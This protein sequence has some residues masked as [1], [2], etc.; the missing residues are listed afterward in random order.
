VVLGAAAQVGLQAF[1]LRKSALRVSLNFRHPALK[2]ILRLYLP[3]LGGLSVMLVGVA[4]DRNLA[5][6]TG[7]QSLAWMQAATY[8]VQLPLGLVATA[9]SFAILPTL[10]RAGAGSDFRRTLVF[11]LKVVLF[12]MLPCVVGLMILAQP[13]VALLYEHGAFTANDTTQTAR[14]IQFYLLGTTFAAIDQPLVFAF[15]ARR[16]T[17]LPNLVAVVGLGIY[18][19]VALALIQ[20]LGFLALV[21]AN[22]AQLAGHALVMLF[23]TQTRLG[24]LGGEGLGRTTLKLVG[25]SALMAAVMF[26]LPGFALTEGWIQKIVAVLVPALVGGGVYVVAL[27][28][29]RVQELDQ[30]WGVVRGR[31]VRPRQG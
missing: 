17:L 16:N 21:L 13:V 27:K 6:R 2:Q 3:V 28:L 9:I 23:F 19:V 20:P 8:L 12:L 14:A 29:L 4:I 1:G 26:L 7:A 5:S 15:Y 11:G 24:G 18:L 25:A 22:S 30:M 10:S 31:L